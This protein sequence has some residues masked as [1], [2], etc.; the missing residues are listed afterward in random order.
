MYNCVINTN[1]SRL[2]SEYSLAMKCLI[3]HDY[4]YVALDVTP[5]VLNL[6]RTN[7]QKFK[8]ILMHRRKHCSESLHLRP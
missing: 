4:V 2:V 3:S 5:I 1:I 6:Q 7:S 8:A